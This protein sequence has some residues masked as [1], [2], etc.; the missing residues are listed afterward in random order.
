MSRS[1]KGRVRR[2]AGVEVRATRDQEAEDLEIL[3]QIVW[4]EGEALR[5]LKEMAKTQPDIA[6]SLETYRENLKRFSEELAQRTGEPISEGVQD[7]LAPSA[8]AGAK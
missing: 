4:A 5:L 1:L 7:L 6:G 3:R 8:T 2:L